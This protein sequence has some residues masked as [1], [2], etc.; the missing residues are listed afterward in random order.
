MGAFGGPDIVDDGL[1][2]AV[3]AG[4][5]RTYP[6]NNLGVAWVDYGNS[7]ALGRYS[8]VNNIQPYSILLNTTYN[9]W[10]GY[11]GLTVPSAEDYT[12]MFDYVA[13]ATSSMYLDNDGVDN[14]NWNATIAVTTSVQTYNVTKAVTTTG[15]INF[16]TKR[17]SGGNITISNFRFFKSAPAFNIIN[18]ESCTLINDVSFSTNNGGTWGFDG[19]DQYIHGVSQTYSFFGGATVEQI[20]KPTAINRQQGFFNLS[21]A[22]GAP[23]GGS[24]Y[25]NFWMSTNNLMRWE[26]IGDQTSTY[27]T[28]T[29]TTAVEVGKYYHFVGV[30]NGSTT[31]IYVNG[32]AETTQTMGNQPSS[33]T[34]RVEIGRYSATYPS[35]S[36]IA[37]TRF[38]NQPL[39]AA[40]VLQNYNAQ[41]NR[42]I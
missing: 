37:V 38:Y 12:I 41:K 14:N 32:V 34:S 17:V 2:F 35:A 22:G 39:T 10:V 8:I 3:D 24:I 27:S 25:I 19:V 29:A 23:S 20:I 4:S 36:E 15:A 9:S 11:F 21:E 26:V 5:E 33:V 16:F 40:E 31:T 7:L 18:N 28:I 30:F 1:V 42:F 6:R 13:D